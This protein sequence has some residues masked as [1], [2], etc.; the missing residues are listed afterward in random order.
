MLLLVVACALGAAVFNLDRWVTPTKVIEARKWKPLNFETSQVDE[1]ILTAGGRPLTLKVQDLFWRVGVP[2][3]DAADPERVEKLLKALKDAEWL[4]HVDEDGL[5]ADAWKMTGLGEQAIHLEVKGAG[6]LVAECWVGFESSIAGACYLSVPGLNGGAREHYVARSD[7]AALVKTPAE[8]WRDAR[9]LHMPPDGVSSIT[10][11]NGHGLIELAREKPKAPWNIVKPLRTRG[12][13]QRINELLGVLLDLKVVEAGTAGTPG[14]YAPADGLKVGVY[15]PALAKPLELVLSTPPVGGEKQTTATASHRKGDFKISNE[16]LAVLWSKLNDLRDDHLARVD[17]DR[18]EHL[19]VRS[20]LAG[21]VE[22]QKAGDYWMLHRHGV[23]VPANGDRVLKLFEEL[24]QHRVINFASDSAA[25]LEPYGLSKPFV[26][27]KWTDASEDA[28]TAPV[29][30]GAPGTFTVSPVVNVMKELHFGAG[31]EG[32]WY[33]KYDSEPFVY[34]I[35]PQLVNVLPRDNARWK[36]LY[37]ARFTQFALKQVAIALST[38][39][40]VVLDYDPVLAAWSGNVAGKDIR[41]LIDRVKADAMVA[42][43]AGLKA[44]D[45]LQDRTEAARLLQTPA[46]TVRITLLSDPL[47]PSS[48]AKVR[49]YNFSPTQAGVD[50]PIY[51]GR[52]D[53]DPDIFVIMR[54][55]LRAALASVLKDQPK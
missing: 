33:A 13:D 22:L 7:L 14:A 48:P 19:M 38:N 1:I 32:K 29:Q 41:D 45:W 51:Y 37:P 34:Q 8:G 12:S 50:T 4:E 15:S 24:N 43:L 11:Q 53:A 30:P 47:N 5:G 20:D 23:W 49:E 18:I 3:E 21:E 36:S 26:T 54:D 39:P 55:Q 6:V 28:P 40:P 9:L 44:E 31:A 17:A 16:R 35:S 46:I 52:L 27:L 25:N 10:L 2:V 42:K